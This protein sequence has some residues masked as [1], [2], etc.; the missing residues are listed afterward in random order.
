MVDGTPLSGAVIT[1]E[2]LS[3]TP[4]PNA[5]SHVFDGRFAFDADSGL[6]GGRYRVRIAMLPAEILQTLPD[7]QRG[8]LPPKNAVVDPRFDRNSKLE[9]EL[10][11][12]QANVFNFEITFL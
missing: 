7:E 12:G 2:P 3:G 6:L 8:K 5:S 1:L 11:R 9:C 4:G 10:S